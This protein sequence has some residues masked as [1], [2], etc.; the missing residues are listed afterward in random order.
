VSFFKAINTQTSAKSKP[1]KN[2]E[3]KRNIPK[4]AIQQKVS[5]FKSS[6]ID[7]SKESFKK[8]P[9]STLRIQ[10]VFPNQLFNQKFQILN[11]LLWISL[12]NHLKCFQKSKIQ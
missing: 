4:S 7:I 11:Y 1:K 12:M 8:I 2:S 9:K 3:V 10:E 5:N 6:L